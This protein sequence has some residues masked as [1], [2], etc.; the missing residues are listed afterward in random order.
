MSTTQD[1]YPPI[2]RG[3]QEWYFFS[4]RE[5]LYAKGNVTK[6]TVP[7]GYWNASGK[8][9][10]SVLFEGNEIGKWRTMIF[11]E[12][13]RGDD[14]YPPINRGEHEWYFFSPREKLYAKGNV[15]KRTVPG[16]YWNASGKECSSVLFEGNEIGKWRTMIFHEGKRGDGNNKPTPWLMREYRL[17]GSS[18]CNMKLDDWVLYK[19]YVNPKNYRSRGGG[20][21]GFG[22][23]GTDGRVF[24]GESTTAA[25]ATTTTA[26]GSC[27]IR[28]TDDRVCGGQS[29][30][31]AAATTTTATVR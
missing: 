21:R 17:V 16:G 15:T 3:E 24:G 8:E 10:S 13:K 7:G 9:C 4:P 2:N 1:D 27:G 18:H 30:T 28:G 22:T 25:E 14:D 29:T 11:H 6:R 31:V 5:K 20:S 26:F 23:G 12:G 19:I